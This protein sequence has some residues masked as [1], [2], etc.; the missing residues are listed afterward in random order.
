[1][2]GLDLWYKNAVIYSVDVKT[3][4]DGNGDGIGDFEGLTRRLDYLAGLGVTCLWL[5]PF[6]PTP[7]RDN[8]Y[9]ICDF[10]N[11]D[12]RLGDLGD[13]VEFMRQARMRGMRVIIDLVINH[14]SDEHPWFQAA[15][16]DPG[17]KYRE[18]Y[19]WSEEEPP[20][21]EQGVV[22]PG[23]Q[24]AIWTFDE[25]ARAWYHH[26]FYHFQPDLN[27][28]SPTVR[29]EI[30]KIMGF[31][32]E[33]GISGFRMDAA[34]FVIEDTEGDEAEAPLIY[35]F[36]GEFRDFLSWRGVDAI[37]LAEANVRMDKVMEYFGDGHRLQ[38][39]FNFWANQHLFLSFAREEAGPLVRGLTAVPPIPEMG[40]WANFL[41]NHDEIDLGRL[42]AFEREDA[43][44]AFGPEPAMQLYERG[45][46]R[47]LAPMLKGDQ[48]R[49]R[50][51]MSLLFTLPGTP[52]IWYGD[53]I[54]MGED[55]SLPERNSVR[56]PM[57]WCAEPNAGF[58]TAPSECLIRPVVEG[59]AFGYRRVNAS[60]QQRDPSSLLN[61]VEKM[62][63]VRKEHREFGWGSW[64][65]IDAQAPSVFAL[66]VEHDGRA[67]VAAHNL[68]RKPC[69]TILDLP[70][71]EAGELVEVL[72]D[73]DYPPADRKTGSIHL[74]GYGFRWFRRGSYTR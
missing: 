2:P 25:Q 27:V 71:G 58:S 29:A 57:Q 63:R 38:M 59:G 20:N 52:V 11:V 32:L 41:R 10:Y 31:W 35:D 34:P 56:T 66:R 67:S 13:F 72:A 60:D 17:S 12:P 55:L 8:G 43:F 65:V 28:A 45:V 9:D 68:S 4:M 36:L 24:E 5:L 16:T 54:G 49:I 50:L 47:R 48:R 18:Y 51:A 7:D 23:V 14:T 39:M 62:I 33:L 22:F 6:Y 3:Y 74:D 64:Q 44:R 40:Q 19:I 46:R 61:Y 1:M 70:E 15:R 53:E 26:R 30:R 73:G 37:I 42:S 69:D 21:K